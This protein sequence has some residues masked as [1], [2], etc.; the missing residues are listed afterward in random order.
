MAE[1]HRDRR[2]E[3]RRSDLRT[4]RVRER[5]LRPLAPGEALFAIERFSLTANNLTYALLGERLGYWD[6]FPAPNGWGRIPVWGYLR[7]VESRVADIEPDRYAYG[8]CPPGSHVVLT[9]ERVSDLGF[10]DGAPHRRALDGAYNSYTWLDRDPAHDPALSAELLVL[11][12]LFWLSFLLDDYVAAEPLVDRCAV[13]VSSASSKAAIGAAQL[14]A[15]RD[16]QVVGLTSSGNLEFVEATGAYDRVFVYDD[17]DRLPR[18]PSVLLDVAGRRGLRDHV[19]RHLDGRLAQ[20]VV[21]GATHLDRDGVTTDL[22]EEGAVF[23]FVP[24]QMRRRAREIGWTEL[25]DRYCRAVKQFAE[26]AASWLR[27]QTRHGSDDVGCAYLRVLE[28]QT[29]PE[30]ALVLSLSDVLQAA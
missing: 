29:R 10:V 5:P 28:N 27:I 23:F 15:S 18:S 11:R 13:I 12:P 16:A 22:A 17:I 21:A 19:R 9:P 3:V 20:T 2:L 25:N 4:A 26:D 8:L 6:V 30:T 14:L 1:A 7:V 24:E